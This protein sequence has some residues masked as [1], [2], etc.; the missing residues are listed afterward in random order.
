MDSMFKYS[1]DYDRFYLPKYRKNFD[2]HDNLRWEGRRKF[3]LMTKCM[4][5]QNQKLNRF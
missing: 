2:T 3:R 1:G 4:Y 5:F